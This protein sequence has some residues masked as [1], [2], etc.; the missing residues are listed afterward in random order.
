MPY[1]NILLID[2]D[3][4]DQEIFRTALEKVDRSVDCTSLNNAREALNKLR[5]N[6][7]N[8]DLIFLDLNMPEMNGQQF[9][10]EIKNDE[11]LSYIPIVILSTSSHRST[12]DL[13]KE[14][15]AK[16]FYSKPDRFEDLI[17]I[18]KSVLS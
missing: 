12:I 2:D 5:A 15:G 14:L 7:L 9:L 17:G 4:D 16:E 13:T 11:V 10:M 1:R 6:Q 3:E 8:P 18:I